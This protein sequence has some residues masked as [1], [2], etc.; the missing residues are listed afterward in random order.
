MPSQLK[1]HTASNLAA[2]LD[3]LFDAAYFVDRE[4]KIQIWNAGAV[5]LTG[6]HP[7]E[8]LQRCCADNILVH[9]DDGGNQLCKGGCPLQKTLE[10]GKPR[11]TTVFMRHK[12]GYRVPVSIRV[13]P[14]RGSRGE[15]TGA[16]ETFRVAG[17]PEYW[18][19]RIAELE[20]LAFVDPLTGIP[21]RRFVDQQLE[22]LQGDTSAVPLAVSMLD[23]D[24]FKQANDQYGHEAGDRLLRALGQTLLNCIRATDVLGRWGGDEFLLLLPQTGA[25]KAKQILGR[26]RLLVMQTVAKTD[27]DYITPT[28]S[29]G[30]AVMR[31]GEDRNSLLRRVDTQL[32][33]A[34]HQ[35]KNR[36]CVE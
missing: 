21:N 10:D 31:P 29:I 3:A 34:K 14:V 2:V 4:R 9:V 11:Q 1:S 18:K 35:G 20:Q 15:V 30:A 12:L 6:Y 22:R 8:V 7:E 16:V 28:V 24:S 17:E 27:S 19:A 23:I 26:A 25:E 33:R 32:Y 5:S 13:V 36:C